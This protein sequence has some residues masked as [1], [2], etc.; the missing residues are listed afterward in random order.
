M[1][2]YP[3]FT[4][5]HKKLAIEVKELVDEMMPKSDEARWKRELPWEI[6]ERINERGYPGAGIDKEYG[7][8]GLGATGAC[9]VAEEIG[10]MPGPGRIFYRE[11]VRRTSPDRVVRE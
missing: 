3:W 9:I 1:E 5:E 2:T 6:M 7:G 4:E 10:R 8:M 11:H